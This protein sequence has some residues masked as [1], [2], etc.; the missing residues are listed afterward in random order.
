VLE[1]LVHLVHVV[2]FSLCSLFELAF[3]LFGMVFLRLDQ[4]IQ[5]GLDRGNFG[6]LFHQ[7]F[8]RWS[9]LWWHGQ[10]WR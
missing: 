3:N 8:F 6:I 9:L 2:L 7:S 1:S 10:G 4:L 5:A